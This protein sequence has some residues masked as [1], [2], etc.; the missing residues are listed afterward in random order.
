[1]DWPTAAVLITAI[2]ALMVVVSVW[3][4]SRGKRP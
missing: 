4:D 2:V 1:M 3:I